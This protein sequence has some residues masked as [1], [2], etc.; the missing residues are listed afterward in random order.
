MLSMSPDQSQ[1]LIKYITWFTVIHLMMFSASLKAEI[2]SLEK[3]TPF[4]LF[5]NVERVNEKVFWVRGYADAVIAFFEDRG[6]LEHV[7]RVVI[8]R[9]SNSRSVIFAGH[10]KVNETDNPTLL[11]ETNTG[12]FKPF[13]I[14]WATDSIIFGAGSQVGEGADLQWQG[15]RNVDSIRY[16]SVRTR[17]VYPVEYILDLSCNKVLIT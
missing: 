9:N 17:D 11:L 3:N 15:T 4:T 13:W 14:K 8:G 10:K 6:Q 1:L 5:R 2:L 12:K 16:L 7:F